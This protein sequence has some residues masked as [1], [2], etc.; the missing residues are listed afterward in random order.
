MRFDAGGKGRAGQLFLCPAGTW[1]GRFC[2]ARIKALSGWR[3]MPGTLSMKTERPAVLWLPVFMR[4]RMQN[5]CRLGWNGYHTCSG[6]ARAQPVAGEASLPG[7]CRV[8]P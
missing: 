6:T 8:L 5:R 4:S 7:A 2:T 3:N 1:S